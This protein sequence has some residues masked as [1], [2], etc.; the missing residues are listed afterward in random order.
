MARHLKKTF[1]RLSAKTEIKN[2]IILKIILSQKTSYSSNNLY[3]DDYK[4][5]NYC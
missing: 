4:F 5:R 1:L 3:I 2:V